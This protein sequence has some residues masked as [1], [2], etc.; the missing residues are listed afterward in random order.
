[1]ENCD[2]ECKGIEKY[3]PVRIYNPAGLSS[4]AYR[5]GTHGRFK[6]QMVSMI[7][8]KPALS[9]LTTRSDD[10]L[11][12]ALLDSWA[13]IADVLT[14]YQERIANEGFLTTATERRSVL[15]LARSIG[16][17]LRQGVAASTFLAFK[18]D[19]SNGSPKKITIESGTKVQSI[20][21]KDETPQVFETYED[22]EARQEW[23]GIKPRQVKKQ[24]A[25]MALAK[26]QAILKGTATKLRA[27]DGLLFIVQGS[28]K[29][30]R[31]AKEIEIDAEKQITRITFD[32]LSATPLSPSQFIGDGTTIDADSGFT[33]DD[34]EHIL[35][36]GIWTEST[37]EAKAALEGWS[38][39]VIVDAVNSLVGKEEETEDGI[40]AVRTKSGV[41]GQTAPAW[42]S[43]PPEMRYSYK[44]PTSVNANNTIDPPYP[45]PWDSGRAVNKNSKGEDRYYDEI[46]KNLIYLDNI[47]SS[48]QPNSWVVLKKDSSQSSAF[49]ISATRED[50]LIEFALSGKATGLILDTS[51]WVDTESGEAGST[52]AIEQ[53]ETFDFRKTTV[54]SQPEKLIFVD[55][56]VDDETVQG[57]EIVLEKMVGW[58]HEGQSLVIEGE[59]SFQPG[60][61]K[62][63]IANI[64]SILHFD[65]DLL[66]TIKLPLSS[67]LN[68]TYKRDTVTIN[69]NVARATHGETKEEAIGSGDPTQRFQS[70]ALKESPLTFVPD[71]SPSGAKNT[72]EVSI[73]KVKWWKATSF[74]KLSESDLAYITRTSNDAR[75]SVILGDGV[76]GRLP[77]S[78][79]E[80]IR[81]KYR[82][83]IG[84]D[85]LID[86]DKL[87]LLMK[88]P[89]GVKS[90]TNPLATTGAADPEELGEARKNSPRTALTLDRIVSLKDFADFARG[91]AGV[92]KATSY[93]IEL[94]EGWVVLVA[95]ASS[96]GNTVND[97][98]ELYTTLYE[99]IEKYKDP[100]TTF[101]LRSYKKR[102]FNVDARILV[103]ADM[104][105]EDVKQ[106]V[107]DAL[108]AAFSFENRDFGEAVTL[109]EVISIMQKVKG[110]KAVD[111]ESLY[112]HVPSSISEPPKKPES[113]VRATGVKQDGVVIPSLLTINE[114]G[115]AVEEMS[116]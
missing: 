93:E 16:Y 60:I 52:E 91:F 98:D 14:F 35:S 8:S 76:K 4:I 49:Y 53:L 79:T 51:F 80:N 85:G 101:L 38:L 116:A 5:V 22:I 48:I 3:T 47:Y 32:A 19:E 90:V 114:E 77:P 106:D 36:R 81:A 39:D 68:Y 87:T 40:Y 64:D 103:S 42:N 65:T 74:E 89:L 104:E 99:T 20:P 1:M 43:L 37:L 102:A 61:R 13:T 58:L 71:L 94:G 9:S 29:A 44:F 11:S 112:E 78:G 56:P 25:T 10:D 82:V 57:Q 55:M 111:V 46:S 73:D 107:E 67:P 75:T 2:S 100:S 96:E 34:I 59:I 115:I 113:I 33:S 109:S 86:A 88:R 26:G 17:E 18:L 83:G 54:Y 72:L 12:I 7:S 84:T 31:I 63:E 105:F 24:Y 6:A 15:E 21:G 66:T 41:F 95:I 50:S 30:F 92:G 27:G 28:P 97:S 62:R 70:F 108:K 23:N 110:V 69:A 45:E